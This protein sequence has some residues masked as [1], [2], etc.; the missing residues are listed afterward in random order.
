[1]ILGGGSNVLFTKDFD[2]IVILMDL[3]KREIIK[4]SDTEVFVEVGAGVNWD[5]SSVV[6]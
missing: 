3:K 2:G 4:E 5:D 6:I 1:M